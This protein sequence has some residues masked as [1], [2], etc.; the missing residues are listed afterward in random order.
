VVKLA[1]DLYGLMYK[2]VWGFVLSVR[3]FASCIQQQQD[4]MKQKQT[5]ILFQG[6]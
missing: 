6:S 3:C 4:L 5:S 1:G 2:D